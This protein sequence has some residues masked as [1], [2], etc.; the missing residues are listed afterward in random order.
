MQKDKEK[1]QKIAKEKWLLIH[2][3]T[4]IKL[5]DVLSKSTDIRMQWDNTYKV[6]KGKF[7]PQEFFIQLNYITQQR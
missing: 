4:Q 1:I 2:K 3:G 7:C 5:N 6:L